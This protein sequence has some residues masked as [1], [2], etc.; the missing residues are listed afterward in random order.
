[1]VQWKKERYARA[2]VDA[3]D[4]RGPT[5]DCPKQKNAFPLQINHKKLVSCVNPYGALSQI[6]KLAGFANSTE[7]TFVSILTNKNKQVFCYFKIIAFIV[8]NKCKQ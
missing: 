4:E 2:D 1:M 3:E 8:L 5:K 6:G 7:N